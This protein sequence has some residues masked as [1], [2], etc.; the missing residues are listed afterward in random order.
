MANKGCNFCGGRGEMI[1]DMDSGESRAVRCLCEPDPDANLAVAS[2][3]RLRH[4]HA[5][6]KYEMTAI[7]RRDLE[8]FLE[9]P[10]TAAVRF[11]A[12]R[13]TVED[14]EKQVVTLQER[15]SDREWERRR[16]S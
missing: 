3:N 4:L 7:D 10:N 13:A 16:L 15:L 5:T 6:Y 1:V 14:L 8:L 11:S 2:I 12:D 9:M